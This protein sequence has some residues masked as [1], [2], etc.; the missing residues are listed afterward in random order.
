MF[1][2]LALLLTYSSRLNDAISYS[3]LSL[4]SLRRNLQNRKEGLCWSEVRG[5]WLIRSWSTA[6]ANRS[7][8]LVMEQVCLKSR[9]IAVSWLN[10][11]MNLQTYTFNVRNTF[12]VVAWRTDGKLLKRH[13]QRLVQVNCSARVLAIEFSVASAVGTLKQGSSLL[14]VACIILRL[15]ARMLIWTVSSDVKQRSCLN[16]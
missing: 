5:T 15:A 14:L 12:L 1:S 4:F 7:K 2:C 13:T 8:K 10:I 9:S 16:P 6:H 11:I 3:L